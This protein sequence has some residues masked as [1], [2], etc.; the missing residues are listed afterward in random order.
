MWSRSLGF[1]LL[2]SCTPSF[3]SHF[4]QGCILNALGRFLA[5]LC[6]SAMP[7][8]WP[9]FRAVGANFR[10]VTAEEGTVA[11]LWAVAGLLLLHGLVPLQLR[12]GA[13]GGCALPA[14]E[15]FHWLW[16]LKA[17]F[18]E[19]W[20]VIG[21]LISKKRLFWFIYPIQRHGVFLLFSDLCLF[22]FQEGKRVWGFWL[23]FMYHPPNNSNNNNK[24]KPAQIKSA[25]SRV[26]TVCLET[27][28]EK[29][30]ESA[31]APSVPFSFFPT[32]FPDK[33]LP[34]LACWK[35]VHQ[36]WAQQLHLRSVLRVIQLPSVT[37]FETIL[38]GKPRMERGI[39]PC[40]RSGKVMWCKREYLAVILCY[41]VSELLVGTL[42]KQIQSNS[43][44]ALFSS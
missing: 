22:K 39:S 38:S 12:E 33:Q 34:A 29:N 26:V 10:N 19:L 5:I 13:A 41:L 16:V 21:I 43:L 32:S 11:N 18:P 15:L 20:V 8:C 35:E 40:P 24:T 27:W 44:N 36:A 42:P 25:I 6:S 28:N 3:P 1:W 17:A 14:P 37:F 31:A 4:C 9:A 30:L 23:T 2:A 7:T